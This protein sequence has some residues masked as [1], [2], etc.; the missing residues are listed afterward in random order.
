VIR[1]DSS[2][3]M[4]T[5]QGSLGQMKFF[6]LD[7]TPGASW[8][9]SENGGVKFNQPAHFC[10]G[11]I[12]HIYVADTL[13][14]MIQVFDSEGNF[15]FRWGVQG[16]FPGQLQ[17]PDR[18]LA[19]SNG[20]IYVHE[21]DPNKVSVFTAEGVYVRDLPAMPGDLEQAEEYSKGPGN[22]WY[23]FRQEGL[24]VFTPCCA[25]TTNSTPSA[26]PCLKV[27]SSR[28]PQQ[29]FGHYIASFGLHLSGDGTLYTVE[30]NNGYYRVVVFNTQGD[31]Q[32]QFPLDGNAQGVLHNV[33]GFEVDASGRIY[34]ADL[35]QK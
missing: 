19:D 13:N 9:G 16:Q 35:D 28:L 7:G 31:I 33:S 11:I 6:A 21:S 34:V 20:I 18:V 10:I 23:Q 5:L 26:V 27:D 30:A 2:G 1:L 8:D 3:R 29:P 22:S 25:P 15:L 14:N 17:H 24:C 32:F 12:G 4:L